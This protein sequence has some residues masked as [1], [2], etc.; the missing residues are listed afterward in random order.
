MYFQ[1]VGCALRNVNM[2]IAEDVRGINNPRSTHFT[3][4]QNGNMDGFQRY[5]IEIVADNRRQ[6]FYHINIHENHLNL[7]RRRSTF[8]KRT[9]LILY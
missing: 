2:R 3:E 4:L 1:Y 8:R 9:K 6:F 7:G 5:G